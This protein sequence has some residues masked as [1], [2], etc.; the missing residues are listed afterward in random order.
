M[1]FGAID[2][3]RIYRSIPYGPS[4]EVLLLDQ[5]TYR[6][7]NTGNRQDKPSAETVFMGERQIAW[8]KKRLVESKATWKVIGSD[9]PIGL[10]IG[11]KV[12]GQPAFEGAANGDGPPLG[13][14]HEIADLL[15]FIKEKNI[16]NIVWLT[17]DVHYAAAH[18]Y[19][20]TKAK[21]GDFLPFWEFVGGP[22]HAGSFGP[23]E[24]DD[25]FGPQLKFH[26]V[27]KG[28]KPNRPPSEGLQFFGSVKI[29]GKSEA[30]TVA[31]HNLKGEVVYRVALEVER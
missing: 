19:D 2:A 31:I 25:T 24:L 14:E 30:M 20:P 12:N 22:L 15:K 1:R 29:D 18:F 21:F 27:P 8:L 6:G 9:M 23:G 16:R 28:M 4:L 10:L 26:T 7:P 17:A 11:D 5:R 13:R 3:E